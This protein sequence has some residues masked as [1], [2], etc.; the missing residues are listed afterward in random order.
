M[1]I[2]DISCLGCLQ[3]DSTSFEVACILYSPATTTSLRSTQ[4]VTA[5]SSR[6]FTIAT[7]T[8]TTP[9][10]TRTTTP[11]T[12][13]SSSS[14]SATDTCYATEQCDSF[15]SSLFACN[16]AQE[17]IK[18]LTDTQAECLCTGDKFME[19]AEG[20]GAFTSAFSIF[21]LMPGTRCL[22]CLGMAVTGLQTTCAAYGNSAGTGTAARTIG[23]T[24]TRSTGSA[25]TTGSTPTSSAS[26]SLMI[27]TVLAGS[28]GAVNHVPR[29]VLTVVFVVTCLYQMVLGFEN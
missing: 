6:F 1:L 8:T 13:T 23:S 7:T 14:P 26:V 9:T 17:D 20:Y 5:S 25:S 19:S 27:P 18:N 21:V 29:F 16:V 4:Q 15:T 10:S 3:V 12:T 11:S 24:S 28:S 2:L 22:A